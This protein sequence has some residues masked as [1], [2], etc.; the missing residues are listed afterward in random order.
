M[1][2]SAGSLFKALAVVALSLLAAVTGK[3]SDTP[4]AEKAGF[5]AET[6][7]TETGPCVAD[8]QTLCLNGGRFKVQVNWS[9]PLQG[10]NGAGTGVALTGDTGY[11]WFFSDNNIELVLKVVDGR[12]V[13]SK[14]W[15]FYGALTNVA[16][17]ISITDTVAGT[18][19]T[20]S[21]PFGSLP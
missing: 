21:N 2:S 13:N 10:T 7:A 5:V 16:Y 12:A 3:P 8:A 19:R 18:V 17:V 6:A 4:P 1:I 9:V 14:F 15:V 20:Y 11:F